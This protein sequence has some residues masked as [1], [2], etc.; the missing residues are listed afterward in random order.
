M[1][2]TGSSPRFL[3]DTMLGRL[4][5]WLR[6]MGCDTLY[7]GPAADADLLARARA[8]GRI[9]LTRD[10]RLARAAGSLGCLV[11]AE[12]LEAQLAE[13]VD[14]LGLCPDQAGWL[15]RCLQCN[16]LLEPRA[17]E[18]VR[19]AVPARVFGTHDAFWACPTCARVYWEGS[20]T[21]RI[22]SRLDRLLRRG[23]REPTP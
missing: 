20:H 14:R 22:V 8:E 7:P 11:R 6:A 21:D 2:D 13:V 18:A 12:R 9:L 17:P 10:G 4:A 5:H 1:P 16:S 3:V 23:A 19:H 15:S